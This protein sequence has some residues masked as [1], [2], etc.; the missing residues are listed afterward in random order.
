MLWRMSLHLRQVETGSDTA[1]TLPDTP[2]LPC[3]WRVSNRFYRTSGTLLALQAPSLPFADALCSIRIGIVFQ[4][5]GRTEEGWARPMRCCS[6]DVE[7][8]RLYNRNTPNETFT[9]FSG[10]DL[11]RWGQHRIR[12]CRNSENRGGNGF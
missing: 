2:D 11:D 6:V 12:G 1:D 3:G 5:A 7:I 8:Y 10:S 4:F 9:T